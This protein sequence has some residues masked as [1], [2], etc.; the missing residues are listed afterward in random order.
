M[1][2]CDWFNLWCTTHHAAHGAPEIDGSAL[3]LAVVLVL[4]G[5]MAMRR[6]GK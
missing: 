3:R 4:G 2:L 1:M 6:R 5:V